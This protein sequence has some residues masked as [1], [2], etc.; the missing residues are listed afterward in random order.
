MKPK[1]V[2]LGWENIVNS[3]LKLP[4]ETVEEHQT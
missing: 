4:F 3:Q 1:H 2:I